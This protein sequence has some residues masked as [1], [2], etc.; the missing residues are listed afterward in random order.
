MKAVGSTMY[1]IDGCWPGETP[2]TK[3]ASLSDLQPCKQEAVR[4]VIVRPT[5]KTCSPSPTTFTYF[6]KKLIDALLPF[7]KVS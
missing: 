4:R 3:I 7:S 5:V 1:S 6:L 2:S